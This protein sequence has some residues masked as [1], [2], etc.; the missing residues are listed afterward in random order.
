MTAPEK[1]LFEALRDHER[2]APDPAAVLAALDAGIARRHRRRRLQ[3]MAAA[4]LA[5]VAAVTFGVAAVGGLRAGGPHPASSPSTTASQPPA[6]ESRSTLAFGWL[7][8]G[9]NPPIVTSTKI[10]ESVLYPGSGGRYMM[11]TVPNVPWTPTLDLPGWR[12]TTVN[13]RPARELSQPARSFVV[14][15]LPSGRWG[16][17]E[18]GQGYGTG[19][20]SQPTLH[21]EALRVAKAVRD[22]GNTRLQVGF[23]LRYL[24]AGQH[25]IGVSKSASGKDSFEEVVCASGSLRVLGTEKV[26]DPAGSTFEGPRVDEG[27]QIAIRVSRS[28]LDAGELAVHGRRLPDIQGKPAYAINQ[29][30]LVVVLD[31]HSRELSVSSYSRQKMPLSELVK[32]AEGVRLT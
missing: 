30:E 3:G 16:A 9:L 10:R 8:A 27:D 31:F 14:F 13:G 6:V 32:V 22:A 29:D 4:A 7:P 23:T 15:Q 21:D 18:L 26:D 20:N 11:L 5:T 28:M 1:R 12:R 24:P 25:I 19:G 2:L 17:L